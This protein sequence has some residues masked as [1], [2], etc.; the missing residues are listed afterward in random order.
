M[1]PEGEFPW[2]KKELG[3]NNLHQRRHS[4]P[5]IRRILI[6]TFM[7]AEDIALGFQAIQNISMI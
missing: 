4:E 2:V 3:G 7:V 1:Q 6:L 5:K